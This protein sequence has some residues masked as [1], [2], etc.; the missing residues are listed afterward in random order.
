MKIIFWGA[1]EQVTGSMTFIQIEESLM[2]V[3]CGLSQGLPEV[4]NL[5][6]LALPFDASKIEHVLITHAH[7][8]HS[9]Y[10]PAL[11]RKGFRGLI[12]CTPATKKLMQIILKDSAQL[13]EDDLYDKTEVDKSLQLM[14]VHEWQE[15][16]AL[17]KASVSFISAG[18]ILGASSILLEVD[19]KKVV[20]SGDL[21]REDDPLLPDHS[22]CPEADII[23]M[24]STYG[25]KLRN[26]DMKVELEN[27]LKSI[28]Q[29]SRVGIIASFAVARAQV[30]LKLIHDF[31]ESHPD[32]KVRVVLDSP[33]MVEA[34]RVYQ[35]FAHMT[36]DRV[37]IIETLKHCESIDHQREWESL[38]KKKG[39]LLILSSSGMLTGGRIHRH[40]LNWHD[41]KDAIL[42]LP[43]YQAEG[44]PGR[45]L[46]LG[47]RL[48]HD[49]KLGSFTWT[50]EVRTSEAFSSHADQDELIRWVALKN[51][52][53]KIYLIHGE[54]E[55]KEALKNLLEKK[56]LDVDLPVRGS[57]IVI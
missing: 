10:L 2:M 11:V 16:F 15:T 31:Y 18:H 7:L 17:G 3:D 6:H 21:G 48:I 42:F 35:N 41:D 53:A 37:S 13:N 43:G 22:C 24:E 57:S 14:V 1:T 23:I 50:G 38:K 25:A 52:K 55:S 33:M 5:N 46:S 36:K 44:T 9:G 47:N 49:E 40:L 32:Q 8:D 54:K 12:H 34:N 39:P 51:T 45:E 19:G 28:H 20:F 4:E 56:Q 29:N 30:L 26:G 27:F